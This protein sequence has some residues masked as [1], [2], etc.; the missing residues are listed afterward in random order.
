MSSKGL[1]KK[2]EKI[3]QSYG[4]KKMRIATAESCTGGLISYLLTEVPGA[5]QVF[6][7]GFVTY[8]DQS[9]TDQL[10]VDAKLIAEHG[11]V[12]PEVAEAMARGALA[13]SKADIALAVT[14]IAGPGGGTKKKPVGRV[15]IAVVTR[16]Y[17]EGIVL[18]NDFRGKRSAVRAKSAD[19]SLTVLKKIQAFF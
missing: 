7:R 15:Y 10:G 8:S 13:R 3:I 17:K 6:D 18:K 16:R 14:G 2:S 12:S 1:A 5:S 11:A 4:K 9:K 19:K